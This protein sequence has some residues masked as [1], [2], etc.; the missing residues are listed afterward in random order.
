MQAKIQPRIHA[1]AAIAA[2]CAVLL[3]AAAPSAALAADEQEFRELRQTVEELK[4]KLEQAEQRLEQMEEEVSDNAQALEAA[5]EAIEEAEE[6]PST[7]DNLHIG[8]YGEL[9]YNNL[10]ADDSSRDKKQIDFH[11]FVLF[12]GYDYSDRLRFFSELELEH[13]LA[14]DEA[15]GE[16]ELEQAFVE[17]DFDVRNTARAGLFL[18]PVGLLNETHEPPTFYGVERNVVENVIIPTTWWAGGAGYTHRMDNGI[19]FD[20]ALHEGLNMEKSASSRTTFSI[21]GTGPAMGGDPVTATTATST[22]LSGRIRSGRQ[23][24]A[25]AVAEDLAYTGRV[26][27]TGM[28]GLELALSL[29]YQSDPTQGATPADDGSAIDSAWLYESHVAFNRGPLGLRALYARWDLDAEGPVKEYDKQDGWYLEP[30]YKL[31]DAL[32]VFARFADVSGGRSSDRFKQ[33]TAGF[34]YWLNEDTVLKADYQSRDHDNSGDRGRDY[35]GFNL[36]V[37]YQF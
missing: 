34:S 12:F 13:S 25:E 26:K 2:A 16:V 18:L 31:N 17:Y 4:R 24:T 10:S 11:R 30:S 9:H 23:K 22:T 19:S 21:G 37:G 14:G 27:Y 3:S 15:P 36:G 5:A 7:L 33:W 8:G 29:Q 28:P 1:L 32:G 20:L 6:Q 35:D